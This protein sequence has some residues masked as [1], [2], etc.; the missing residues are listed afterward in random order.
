MGSPHEGVRGHKQAGAGARRTVV[1]ELRNP[2]QAKAVKKTPFA[3]LKGPWDLPRAQRSK[4]AQGQAPSKELYRAY[5]LKETLAKALDYRQPWRARRALKEWLSWA[6]QPKLQL[7][8]KAAWAIRKHLTGILAYIQTRL[9]N[10]LVE[11]IKGNLRMITRRAYGFHSHQVLIGMI[12]LTC[13]GIQLEP[14]LL[15]QS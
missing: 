9:P 6:W 12:F 5:L 8:G 15:T 11:G 2:T 4:I 13:G 7:F 14:P 10:G 1:C 3:L